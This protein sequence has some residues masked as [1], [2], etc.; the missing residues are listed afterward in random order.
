MD[1]KQDEYK[2]AIRNQVIKLAQ[3]I[4]INAA[5]IQD[6]EIIP[7]KG[8]LDSASIIELIFWFEDYFNLSIDDDEITI[9]NFGSVDAMVDFLRTPAFKGC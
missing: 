6:N 7:E 9:D 5:L 4:G 2:T 3:K 8:Y 1:Q